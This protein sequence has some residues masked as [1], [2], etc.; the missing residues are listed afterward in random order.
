MRK[1]KVQWKDP[2]PF[3]WCVTGRYRW[4]MFHATFKGGK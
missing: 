4:A 2:G 3:D 1:R